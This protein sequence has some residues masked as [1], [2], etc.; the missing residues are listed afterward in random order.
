MCE[1]LEHGVP[2]LLFSLSLLTKAPFGSPLSAKGTVKAIV[3]HYSSIYWYKLANCSG[4][5]QS[6]LK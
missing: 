3:S 5:I 6:V 1:T 2:A 4:L